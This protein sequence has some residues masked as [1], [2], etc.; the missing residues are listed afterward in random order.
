M[1]PWLGCTVLSFRGEDK[2]STGPYENGPNLASA[3]V[4]KCSLAT[5]RSVTRNRTLVRA[6]AA[7]LFVLRIEVVA[8]LDIGD[9]RSA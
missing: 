3:V 7:G 1:L 4:Q 5:V 9:F 6:D 8:D 2:R